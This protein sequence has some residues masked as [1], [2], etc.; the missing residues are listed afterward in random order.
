MRGIN[1]IILISKAS[2]DS[3]HVLLDITISTDN[4]RKKNKDKETDVL[5]I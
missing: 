5:Y 2:H 4:K 1:I 3:I